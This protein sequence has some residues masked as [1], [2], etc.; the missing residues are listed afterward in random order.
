M[1]LVPAELPAEL[2]LPSV[3]AVL[4]VALVPMSP[5]VLGSLVCAYCSGAPAGVAGRPGP[6]EHR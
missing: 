1:F 2:A 6:M 4:G 5:M 3:V